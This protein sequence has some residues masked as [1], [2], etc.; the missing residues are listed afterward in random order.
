[1]GLEGIAD[2]NHRFPNFTVEMETGTGKTYVYLRTIYELRQ[3]YGF[4]KF[5]VVV[6]SIAIYE[7]VIKNFQITRDH[8]RPRTATSRSTSSSTT[9]ASSAG[10]ATSPPPTPSWSW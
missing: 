5:V 2:E 1:M 7:G 9:A 4:S 3:R 10:C 6:P 8:F